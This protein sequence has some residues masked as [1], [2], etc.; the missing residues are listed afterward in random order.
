MHSTGRRL[1]VEPD[2]SVGD[3]ELGLKSDPL[4]RGATAV[5]GKLR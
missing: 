2:D 1:G 3:G 4:P 5:G